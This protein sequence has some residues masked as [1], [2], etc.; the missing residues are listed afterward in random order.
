[1]V[2][3]TIILDQNQGGT[4]LYPLQCAHG[5]HAHFLA[6]A[7]TCISSRKLVKVSQIM[8]HLIEL[9]VNQ[10]TVL[11]LRDFCSFFAKQ[12]EW[13]T[14]VFISHIFGFVVFYGCCF[15]IMEALTMNVGALTMLV[16]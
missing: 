15:T 6:W 9:L 8:P 1:M 11:W 13:C 16:L 10:S 7:R 2:L 14:D 5:G 3:T 12:V 4:Y